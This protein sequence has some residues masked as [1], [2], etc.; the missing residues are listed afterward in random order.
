MS[1]S[2]FFLL[3][4]LVPTLMLEFR[5]H[6]NS[7]IEQYLVQVNADNPSITHLYSIGKSVKGQQLWVLAL[8]LRPH[9][10]TVGVPEFKYVANMHGNEVGEQTRPSEPTLLAGSGSEPTHKSLSESDSVRDPLCVGTTGGGAA[11]FVTR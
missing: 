1:S 8:G 3:P 9:R 10:H 6:D 11:R 7:E 2:L 4:L 5:Y